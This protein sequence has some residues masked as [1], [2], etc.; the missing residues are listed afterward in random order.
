VL[1]RRTGEILWQTSITNL[2]SSLKKL[3]TRIRQRFGEPQCCYE[4]SS[5]GFVL[6]RRLEALGVACDVIAPSS[7]PRRS[8]DAV[9]ND[10]IDAEKLAAYYASG[11]LTPVDVPDHELE[12][13]RSLLRCRQA[14]VEE[15][16]RA[17]N[18]TSQ[19]LLTR[20]L[21]FRAGT[22]WSQK[23]RHWL[24]SVQRDGLLGEIDQIVLST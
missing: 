22:N 15:L 20:G 10:R 12:A 14:L 11:L 4:A 23:H 6:Y 8:G 2:A 3:V 13:T 19:F 5:C 7:I 16:T 24:A 9:K 1:N 17:R 21:A 18:R